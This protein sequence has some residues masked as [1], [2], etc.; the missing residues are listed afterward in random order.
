MIEIVLGLLRAADES[1]VRALVGDR[2]NITII[3]PDAPYL[4]E[5]ADVDTLLMEDWPAVEWYLGRPPRTLGWVV[6]DAVRPMRVLLY[7]T[8]ITAIDHEYAPN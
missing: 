7:E 5:R 4:A 3:G 8:T 6:V 2:A 1:V